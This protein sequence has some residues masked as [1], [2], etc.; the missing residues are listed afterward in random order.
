MSDGKRKWSRRDFLKMTG[1]AGLGAAMLAGGGA[2]NAAGEGPGASPSPK[3]VPGRPF[4]KSGRTVSILSLG[5]M[6]DIPS[7]QLLLK[8]ALRWGVTYW[9]TADCYGGG[10]S[11]KG[12]G[13]YFAKYPDDRSRIFLVTKSDDRDPDGLSRLL[14]RS[15]E[16]LNTSYIDLYFVHGISDIDELTEETRKWAEK[17]KTQGKIR[18]FGFSTH[19]NMETCLEAAAKLGWIDGIMMSYNYRLMHTDQMKKAVDACVAAGIGL[20]A[21]K[22]Q[23]GGA[24]TIATETE[25]A[26]AGRF[27]GRGFTDKQAKL[28][29][30]W[31]NPNIASICSQMPNLTILMSNISAALDKTKLAD[32]DKALLDRYARETASGY[33]AGCAHLCESQVGGCLPISDVMRY[34][35]YARTYGDREH[36]REMFGGIPA[37]LRRN[38][39]TM[40]YTAA[41]SICPQKMAIARLM[42]EAS[43]ELA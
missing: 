33:C 14:D 5:G 13:Q 9:D 7:N 28:K 43:R 3:Q 40:D 17:A 15:L 30:V 37:D 12:I 41:E 35:M 18:L 36:A 31:E 2:A 11:E 38:M 24:V 22:T 23:G 6:F 16:R 39:Q 1:Q 26:L 34:L 10:A 29:A 25:L 8:Q 19:R 32:A 20:T 21:M 4:G 27:L 42:R